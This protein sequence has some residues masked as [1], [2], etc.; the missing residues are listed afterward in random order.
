MALGERAAMEG[1]LCQLQPELSIEIGTAE[2]ASMRRIAAHSGEVHSFDLTSPS[3]GAPGNVTLHTGDS[4]QLLPE[5]LHQLAEE[6]LEVGFVLV[7]G[8]HSP[9]GVRRDLEDLLDSPAIAQTVILIHDT[10]NE[11]VR[12]GID[13]VAFE[14]WDKVGHVELD[15]VPGHVFKDS[16]LRHEIWCGLGLVLIGDEAPAYSGEDVYQQRYFDAA[17]LLAEARDGLVRREDG[18]GDSEANGDL[19]SLFRQKSV[20]LGQARAEIAAY[21]KSTSWRLTAP[22]RNLGRRVRSRR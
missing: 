8:D 5:F 11:T 13:S 14:E 12:S 19:A 7:D 16:E 9:E 2:G 21:E 1:V 22:L 18:S 6:G 20:E 10:A 15:W 3:L 17:H 4:H